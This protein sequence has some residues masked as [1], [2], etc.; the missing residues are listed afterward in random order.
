MSNEHYIALVLYNLF[1]GSHAK[2]DE[3][4]Q[5]VFKTDSQVNIILFIYSNGTI[6]EALSG[7]DSFDPRIYR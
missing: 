4:I 3:Q 7:S 1:C 2:M 6:Y 5:L